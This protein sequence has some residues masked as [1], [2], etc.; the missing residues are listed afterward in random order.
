M[1]DTQSQQDLDLPDVCQDQRL[2]YA[3]RSRSS[4]V[5]A[6]ARCNGSRVP[7]KALPV[8]H[9][10]DLVVFQAPS[11][12]RHPAPKRA[13]SRA[14][15]YKVRTPDRLQRR[16]TGGRLRLLATVTVW[17]LCTGDSRDEPN[18]RLDRLTTC[19]A[20]PPT[21]P[22]WRADLFCRCTPI[23]SPLTAAADS[24]FRVT[25]RFRSNVIAR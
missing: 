2:R 22:G 11:L 1:D 23:R 16:F 21:P 14:I 19:S 6:V 20:P 24:H 4:A 10:F 17:V 25:A 5:R 12:T 18:Q 13:P 7:T 15:T 3:S 8:T 9:H